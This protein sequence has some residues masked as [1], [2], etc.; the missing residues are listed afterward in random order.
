MTRR[1]LLTLALA[2]VC[3]GAILWAGPQPLG[4][5][6]PLSSCVSCSKQA[7]QVAGTPSGAFMVVWQKTSGVAAPTS[8]VPG[9]L[10]TSAGTPR[11]DEFSVDP[12]GSGGD[13]DGAV[14]ADPQ[15][16]YVVVWSAVVNGQ[17]D[18]FAQRYTPRGRAVGPVIPVSADDPAAVP[19]PDD[20][21]P[22]VAKSAD[23]G[24][25]VAWKSLQ[26]YGG[27][28][29]RI[30]A[31]RFSP[32]GAPLGPPVQ[33]NASLVSD[34]RP[35]LC[36]DSSGRPVVAWTTVDGYFPFL[37]S[38]MGAAARRLSA[39]GALA[40]PEITVSAPAN[41]E[42]EAA[43]SCGPGNTFVVVWNGDQGPL[44]ANQ[45]EIFAQRF[46]RLSRLA[47]P[48]FRVNTGTAG[49]QAHPRVV[50][51]PTGGFVVVWQTRAATGQAGVFA[52]RYLHDGTTAGAD[53]P[54]ELPLSS[55]DPQA[56][57]APLGTG[58]DFLVVW[59]DG[60]AGLFGRR[61]TP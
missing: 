19:P 39:T 53:L 15:G 18:L 30:L 13:A 59:R 32:T 43:V 56:A 52:R 46:T 48:A 10:F 23:G 8:T 3:P 38:R 31:R 37:P 17:R 29:P 40:G 49:D 33:V 34:N 25:A 41:N 4:Q 14:A 26:P 1:V 2:V 42:A 20:T 6:F 57:V 27:N 11:A 24:F 47:G 55:L 50:Y 58:G 21:L 9:R 45:A 54:I 36:L 35:D 7:P 51:D 61:Y 28:P 16:S 44:V 22:A 5:P 60:A 12:Q